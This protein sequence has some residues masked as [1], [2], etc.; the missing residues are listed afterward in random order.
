M[1]LRTLLKDWLVGPM[2]GQPTQLPPLVVMQ[3]AP[4]ISPAI[5]VTDVPADVPEFK[6]VYK[7]TLDHRA[8][9][10]VDIRWFLG[11]RWSSGMLVQPDDRRVYFEPRRIADKILDPTLVPLV[12][13]AC[14]EI[15]Q[16][17]AEFVA[18]KPSR[19]VDKKGCVW[20]LQQEAA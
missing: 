4:A 3:A 18:S 14:A 12:E 2:D 6:R 9:I 16:L 15:F 17:D 7:A 11:D 13:R 19:I 10:E 20:L 5:A 8:R 1:S